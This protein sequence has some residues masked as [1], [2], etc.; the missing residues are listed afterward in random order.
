[1]Y[2][3]ALLFYSL[4]LAS[5][6]VAIPT[7]SIPEGPTAVQAVNQESKLRILHRVRTRYSKESH[8]IRRRNNTRH[9]NRYA[10]DIE[11]DS[12]LY[13]VWGT[14]T[15]ISGASRPLGGG[16]PSERIWLGKLAYLRK[17]STFLSGDAANFGIM[18]QNWGMLRV[19][20]SQF[21]GQTAAQSSNG[22]ILNSN[23]NYDINDRH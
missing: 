23:L 9:G 11:N 1:M 19:C 13:T 20:A 21:K 5:A 12:R 4:S 3:S 7:S 6:A 18:K 14:G 2:F 16:Y 22:T 15:D 8:H 17:A 10:G